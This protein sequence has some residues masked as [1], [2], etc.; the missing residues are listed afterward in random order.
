[1]FNG[2]VITVKAKYSECNK[3]PEFHRADAFIMTNF[4][5]N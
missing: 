1:M 5:Q 4:N 2:T 3:K